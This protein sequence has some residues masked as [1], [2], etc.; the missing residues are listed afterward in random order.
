MPPQHDIRPEIEY[1]LL[2]SFLGLILVL[3]LTV[4]PPTITVDNPFRKP[5]IGSIFS[6]FC[7]LGILAVF[8]P[9]RC[10]RILDRKIENVLSDLAVTE[11]PDGAATVLRGHHPTCGKYSAHIFRIRDRIFCAACVGLLLGGLLALAGT[12]IYFFCELWLSNTGVLIV[13]LG[14]VGV[15][16]GLFQFKVN[17]LFRLFA[18]ICF[19]IGALLI[20]IGIDAVVHSLFF[21][22]FVICLIVFLLSTRIALSQWDHE[23]ICSSCKTKDCDFRTEKNGGG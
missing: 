5:L 10:G 21:D 23:A 18:N 13:L 3:V 22:L 2:I 4:Y 14:V 6:I 12:V 20:L 11:E 16:F 17:G 1:Y 8:T 7:L 19:V 9:N 15:I